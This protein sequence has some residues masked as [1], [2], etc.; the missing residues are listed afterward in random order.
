MEELPAQLATIKANFTA[1]VAAIAG[2]EERLP[3]CYSLG[4]VEKLRGELKMIPVA[5]N[6]SY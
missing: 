1:V 5:A 3:L 4:N 2:L 6:L